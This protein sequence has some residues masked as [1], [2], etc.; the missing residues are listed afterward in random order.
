MF[1]LRVHGWHADEWIMGVLSEARSTV[2]HVGCQTMW[3]DDDGAARNL[4]ER[5]F[6][7]LNFYVGQPMM[8]VAPFT[9][10]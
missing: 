10:G 9:S 2:E 3:S 5:G 7:G 1:M 8:R 6:Q 4:S